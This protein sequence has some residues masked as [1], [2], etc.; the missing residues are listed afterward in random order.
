TADTENNAGAVLADDLPRLHEAERQPR[1]VLDQIE[2]ALPLQTADGDELERK[3]GLRND[4]LL[5]TVRRP[6]EH[7]ATAWIDAHEFLRNRNGRVNVPACP[8]TRHH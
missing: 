6:D 1:K 3:A 2:T 4:G 7:D 5:E 8:P